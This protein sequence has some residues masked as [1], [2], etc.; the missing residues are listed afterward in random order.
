MDPNPPPLVPTELDVREVDDATYERLLPRAVT[1]MRESGIP[2]CFIGGLAATVHGRPRHTKDL[3]V[4]V[5]PEDANRALE[6]F[7]ADGWATERSNPQW[8][9]KAAT[10]GFLVDLIFMSSDGTVFDP[11]M[12]RHVRLHD[13]LGVQIPLA[14]A[15]DVIVMKV[16]AFREDTPQQWFDCL[17]MIDTGKIDWGYLVDRVRAKPHRVL[18]LLVFAWSNGHPVPDAVLDTLYDAARAVAAERSLP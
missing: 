6:A 9:F 13:H 10:E 12:E 1:V 2:H 4:F 11:E 3:D 16:W 7:A 15:E 5:R 17:A 14:P 8:I 18:S